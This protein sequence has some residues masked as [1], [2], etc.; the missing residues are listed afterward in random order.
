M[1]TLCFLSKIESS[2]ILTTFKHF[3]YS[4]E[5]TQVLLYLG[6]V[7]TK[8]KKMHMDSTSLSCYFCEKQKSS[9][10]KPWVNPGIIFEK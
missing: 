6:I 3:N 10:L 7:C 9:A 1:K 4:I 5:N 8:W 2:I